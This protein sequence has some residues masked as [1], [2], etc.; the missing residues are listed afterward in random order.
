MSTEDGS[1]G[2]RSFQP[3][4]VNYGLFPPIEAPK[5]ENG[6][7]LKGKEKSVARKRAM[8][9][10]ALADL[11]RWLGGDDDRLLKSA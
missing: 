2:S 3:M 7:R 6:K 4:N 10:R 9:H 8:S 11:D 1:G 5:G